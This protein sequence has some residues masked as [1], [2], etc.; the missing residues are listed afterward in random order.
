M[1]QV[2]PVGTPIDN[3]S[4]CAFRRRSAAFPDVCSCKKL[5]ATGASENRFVVGAPGH[6]K[7][8]QE[9]SWVMMGFFYQEQNTVLAFAAELK[10][11]RSHWA[12]EV[13][14]PIFLERRSGHDQQNLLHVLPLGAVV[15]W[16]RGV[17][18][19]SIIDSILQ[20]TRT[21]VCTFARTSEASFYRSSK[22]ILYSF[23]SWSVIAH[24]S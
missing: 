7:R 14:L 1:R 4:S 11:F 2:A 21:H 10:A 6:G 17:V 3:R 13:S 9:L 8:N 16:V 5:L 24:R 22:V 23:C 20:R 18:G 12:I 15:L 19:I